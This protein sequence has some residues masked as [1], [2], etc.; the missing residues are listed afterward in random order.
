VVNRDSADWEARLLLA[1]CYIELGLNQAA[2]GQLKEVLTLQP[3]NVTAS[4]WLK[5]LGI[6]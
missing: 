1:R 6:E 2:E 5:N 4:D 3:E